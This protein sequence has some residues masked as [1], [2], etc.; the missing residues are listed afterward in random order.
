MDKGQMKQRLYKIIFEADTRSGKQFDVVIIVL[1]LLSILAV[2]LESVSSI[3][4]TFGVY[5]KAFE[6]LVTFLFTLEYFV[7]IWI[8]SKPR[9]F[10]FS[11]FGI[12]DLLAF[13]PTYLDLFISGAHGLMVIR[14][15]RLLRIFRVLKLNRYTSEGNLI[16][17]A[18][19][20]S[21]FKI[22]VF[23]YAVLMIVIILGAA[24]YLVEGPEN[25]YQSIPKS[26]YW[27][28]V[29]ITTVGYGDITPQTVIG[30]FLASFI[31][32]LGYAIIAVP[33]GIVTAEMGR[34]HQN[35]HRKSI[36]VCKR[37]L[38]EGHETDALFCSKC[39]ATL[40]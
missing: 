33:T 27:V 29:T 11:F 16:A 38:K 32:I 15:L 25:G 39:G 17:K 22:S 37:C 3:K 21:R 35:E 24:M 12:I 4:E 9:K 1:I 28:I 31:M 10:I 19:R 20:A 18:L 5:L 14:A 13:L 26:M 2:I 36:R 34:V 30:Q 23:L 7:R 6:W 40:D 8:V